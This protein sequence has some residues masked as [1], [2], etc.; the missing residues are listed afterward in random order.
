[1]RRFLSFLF[2]AWIIFIIFLLETVLHWRGITINWSAESE[3]KPV[4]IKWFYRLLF[5]K[6]RKAETPMEVKLRTPDW[7]IRKT[8]FRF[9]K[10]IW[11]SFLLEINHQNDG[12]EKRAHHCEHML[13]RKHVKRQLNTATSL[14]AA[15]V[16]NAFLNYRSEIQFNPRDYISKSNK[17]KPFWLNS[18]LTIVELLMFRTKWKNWDWN[19]MRSHQ[20]K[21]FDGSG[22]Q[23]ELNASQKSHLNVYEIARKL[24]EPTLLISS[25]NPEMKP[26]ALLIREAVPSFI[27]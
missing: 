27:Q 23:G 18:K 19:C 5:A 6:K 4:F 22:G 10:L 8:Q 17:T 20:K 16:R 11:L 7:N 2:G 3:F 25:E 13:G 1:M 9:W 21:S 24:S 14:R 15:R 12:C 26:V